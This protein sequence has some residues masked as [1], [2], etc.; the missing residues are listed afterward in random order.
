MRTVKQNVAKLAIISLALFFTAFVPSAHGAPRSN[1][2]ISKVALRMGIPLTDSMENTLARTRTQTQK[3]TAPSHEELANKMEISLPVLSETVP[4]GDT[5]KT[6]SKMNSHPSEV[7]SELPTLPST[8]P[9]LLPDTPE[10]LA[11]G[12]LPS[13]EKT[14]SRYA[15][16]PASALESF[17]A[18]TMNQNAD[19]KTSSDEKNTTEIPA[20]IPDQLPPLNIPEELPATKPET[21]PATHEIPA[22]DMIL[23]GNP[24][25]KE[26]PLLN[27]DSAPTAETHYEIPETLILPHPKTESVPAPSEEETENARPANNTIPVSTEDPFS[28]FSNSETDSP[29]TQAP[30]SD[31]PQTHAPETPS[32][33]QLPRTATRKMPSRA[34]IPDTLPPPI[35]LSEAPRELPPTAQPLSALP[36]SEERNTSPETSLQGTGIPG[37]KNLEGIQ[38]PRLTVEKTAPAEI[39]VGNPSI[40]SITVR[41][42]GT[43]EAA[44]VQIHDVIP[45]GT[46]LISTSPRAAQDEDGNLVWN[47]G[48]MPPGTMAVV[49]A[50]LMPETEGIVGSVASVTFRAEASAKTVVTRPMLDIQTAGSSRL[51]LGSV[52]E[53]L[54]T[55]SNPGSGITRNIVLSEKVPPEL[56]F[57][58]GAEIL[59]QV[60]DLNPGES[61]QISLPLRAVRPGQL[62]NKIVATADANLR[63]ESDFPLEV[64]APALQVQMEGPAKRFLE[65]D[66][67]YKL[68]L[69]NPGTAPAKNIEMKVTLPHGMNFVSANNGGGYLPE[70]HT[71]CWRLQELPSGD[72]ATAEMNVTLTEIGQLVM[73]YEAVADICPAH[74]GEKSVSVEGIAALMFQVSDTNDP[75]QVGEETTYEISVMNQG[76]RQAE[77]VSV[78]VQ[79]PDGMQVLA[80]KA[81]TAHTTQGKTL[82]F[83]PL[84]RLA[85]KSEVLYQLKVRGI[86]SGDQR[87]SVG[88]SSK[89]FA[90]PI[91]KEESTRVYSE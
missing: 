52:T 41:N 60:G 76:S 86:S 43:K 38:A 45:R 70:N 44:G 79:I 23:P 32:A 22:P 14:R 2:A 24:S 64:I 53:F 54:I 49:K 9:G 80:C 73:K 8:L 51:L 18:A 34:E 21:L 62:T 13:T 90:T 58:G 36:V 67:T 3:L 71:V 6:D 72:S 82:L 46:K 55:V 40:W 37:D 31:S 12:P 68:V 66:G 81:P 30:I 16:M 5:S 7:A 61:R 56:Q 25:E 88:L 87:I 74:H 65:K 20:T 17:P 78:R 29:G 50:E 63:K 83:A 4:E 48:N 75:V 11:D 28:M 42:E 15:V 10:T 33:E 26:L 27:S 89:E 85:P 57:E 39:Q 59:Y 35:H 91:V 69:S 47:V 84:P 1:T 19:N 77:N